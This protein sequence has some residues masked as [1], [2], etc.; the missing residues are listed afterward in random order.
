M[1]V[2]IITV[3]Y[4]NRATVLDAL[5][6][7][8]RQSYKNIE[9]IVIDGCSTDGTVDVLNS[10]KDLIS[11]LVSEPDGGIYD[12]MNK[13]IQRASGDIIGILNSDDIYDNERVIDLVVEEFEADRS[14]D[15]LYSDLVYVSRGN[16]DKIIRKWKSS[17]YTRN[18][19]EYGIVPPH[20]TVFLKKRVY[21]MAGVFNLNFSLAADYEFMLRIFKKHNFN[22]KYV[23][24][25][26]V[27]M[28]LGGATNKSVKNIVLGNLQIFQSWRVNGLNIPVLLMPLK[29]VKRIRQ[30]F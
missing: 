1:K 29:I 25:V 18:F 2:S 19:F 30:F 22:S 28:R 27:K 7:I 20:P 24:E 26:F 23:N 10:N 8:K 16:V 9:T 4:N 11:I 17:T 13:G 12:A 15:I 3:V 21:E 6:S 14:L 5:M